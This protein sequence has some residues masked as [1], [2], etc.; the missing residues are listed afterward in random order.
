M[1]SSLVT[2]AVAVYNTEK[3]LKD[4]MDSVVNQ[5]YQ[6]LEIICVNDCSTDKSLEILEEYAAKDTRIKIITNE[7][8]SGLGVT[9]NVGI[10]AAHGE[11]IL[12]I[13]SDDWLDLT[14]CEKLIPKAKENDSDIV[15]Y[16]AY[17]VSEDKKKE[18]KQF[19]E[20]SCPLSLKDRKALLLQTRPHAWFKLWKLEF[21]KKHE[22]RF[23]D[24]RKAQDQKPHWIMCL[25]AE[26]V[27]FES[28]C[29]YYYRRY[30][31][32]VSQAADMR[33]MMVVDVYNDIDDYLK[34]EDIYSLYKKEFLEKKFQHYN[35]VLVNIKVQFREEFF[36]K[37]KIS[38][39]EKLFLLTQ[40]K[41]LRRGIFL[42]L[43]NSP[44]IRM[45]DNLGRGLYHKCKTT[46]KRR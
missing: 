37:I 32:Q 18:W 24:F 14:A 29:L 38:F 27:A 4:C 20:V 26:K 10:D 12:F 36:T 33:L 7:K 9:R 19:C 1:E 34:R 8:N 43:M 30:N 17:E 42:V 25:F 31:A 44:F 39:S 46:I 21:M 2:I 5:T 40:Y 6:N 11:Y 22:I 23:P 13:D 3:Y 35:F 45:L 15:F 16:S 28:E 41:P